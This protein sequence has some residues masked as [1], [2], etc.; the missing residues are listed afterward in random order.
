MMRRIH[1]AAAALLVLITLSS[2]TLAREV[3]LPEKLD[4][5]ASEAFAKDGPGGSV[6]VVQAGKTLLRKSY[7]MADLELGV[8]AKPEMVFR[9]GS[10]GKQFTAVA[11]LQLVK[12]GK[13][14]F[15]D[16]LSKYVPDFPGAEVITVEQLLTHTSGIRS[17]NDVPSALIG[18]RDDKTPMQL[19]EGIRNEKPAF[20]PGESWMYSNSGYLFLGIIIEKVSGMKYADYMQTKLFTPLGLKHTFVEDEGRIV[21]GRVKGYAIGPDNVLRNAG[22]MN[23]T[24]P[25]AS[26]SIE[27]NVDDL[28]KWNQL[29][30]AGKVIDKALVD[31]AWTESRTKDGK[32]TGYGY[33]WYVSDED[34]VHFVVHGGA[35]TG[36][37]S[38]GVL[39]PEKKLFVGILHN[40]LG[41][42]NDMLYTLKYIATRL[43]LEA[44]GQGWNATPVAMPDAAKSRFTGIYDF[45]GVKRT[46]RVEDGKLSAQQEGGPPFALVPV[47][48]DEFVYDN[49]FTRLKFRMGASGASDSVVFISRGQPSQTGKRVGDATAIRKA[50]T[51]TEEKLDRMLGVYELEPGFQFTITRDGTHL[52][53][54]ATGQ[55]PAEAF[56][57]SETKFFF[58]VVD[59][60]IEFAMGADGRASGLTLLQGGGAMPAKR[61]ESTGRGR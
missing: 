39:V 11:I 45:N 3:P 34:G 6:I 38:S 7:G 27:T 53:M 1:A 23:M 5:I 10:M 17:Y 14:K 50:I 51:L 15:D 61:V 33:G 25:Y 4:A 55:G 16:P 37:R 41:S 21:A 43:A 13:V 2:P 52:F 44:L 30:M 24:F 8:P 29:L 60:Q 48:R 42:G 20:A 57:E 36:F 54:Q 9:I 19:V 47:A 59:A 58:K 26:G 28:A 49:A 31:R 32:P 56:A 18:I 12:E 40:A 35:I 22:Y 46:V